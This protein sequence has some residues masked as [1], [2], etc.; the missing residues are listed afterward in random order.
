MKPLEKTKKYKVLGVG[1]CAADIL[2]NINGNLQE[3]KKIEVR[4]MSF[5]GGGPVANAMSAL[6][7]W[8]VD[9]WF[10]GSIG[11][12]IYGNF[13]ASTFEDENVNISAL[14]VFK[15]RKSAVSV[16]ISHGKGLRTILYNKGNAPELKLKGSYLDILNNMNQFDALEIDGHQ[17]EAQMYAVRECSRLKIP[18]ILDGGSYRDEILPFLTIA[19]HIIVSK[20]FADDF[21]KHNADICGLSK[22]YGVV[23]KKILKNKAGVAIIT[24]GEKGSIGYDG[25]RIIHVSALGIKV[26]DTS[27]AGDIY[28]AGYIFGLLRGWSLEKRMKFATVVAGLKCRGIGGRTPVPSIKEA[29]RVYKQF[30]RYSHKLKIK[31]QGGCK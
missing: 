11:D 20:D 19:D 28:H 13:I 24:L 21:S 30:D 7:K 16:C 23:C 14:Q 17:P 26:V 3:N 1:Y 15:R 18:V 25:S 4:E 12:D 9:T 10:A 22:N 29:M 27:G 5:Q 6:S 31:K 8:G 2:L